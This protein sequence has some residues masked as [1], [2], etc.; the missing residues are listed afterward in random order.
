VT[1]AGQAWRTADTLIEQRQWPGQQL[2][3][4]R[5]A[6]AAPASAENSAPKHSRLSFG[7]GV[8]RPA[9]ASALLR[10]E[11]DLSRVGYMTYDGDLA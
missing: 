8:W 9:G 3:G 10:G 2:A 6:F 1:H 11:M 5:R 4:R 7:S